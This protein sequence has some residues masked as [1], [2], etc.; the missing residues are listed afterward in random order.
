MFIICPKC[1]A[2]YRIPEGISLDDGQK[3]KC[4]ACGFVFMKGKEAPFL[5]EESLQQTQKAESENSASEAFSTPLFTQP[6]TP[7]EDAPADSLPEAFHPIA[8]KDRKTH[9]WA[10]LFYL[11]VIIGL[12]IAGWTYR[13]LLKPNMGDF[14]TI[15]SNKPSG[16]SRLKQTRK[17]NLSQKQPTLKKET[18]SKQQPSSLNRSGS[19]PVK[20]Q[21]VPKKQKNSDKG[22]EIVADLKSVPPQSNTVVELKDKPISPVS[23]KDA[24][25][26]IPPSLDNA[27]EEVQI[28]LFTGPEKIPE[29]NL[30]IDKI[31]FQVK[32]DESG[33]Q[34]L[35]V[36]GLLQNTG[37]E[38]QSV[39]PL[40]VQVFN[41]D[42]FLLTEKKIHV[43]V[44][45][46]LP[47]QSIPFY[48]G[49]T[50]VPTDV[51]HVDVK[52]R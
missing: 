22:M 17:E 9:P 16:S 4:S 42:N 39:F 3:M 27:D 34:Q 48:T 38:V 45:Q 36:E 18:K 28:P 5:L 25:P 35:L 51:D 8:V 21:S 26:D 29:A 41:K 20:P 31:S 19:V 49:I 23:T 30:I 7:A 11:I 40:I 10:I 44:E 6:I 32:P 14:W 2:K 52:I 43:D 33:N 37:S 13:D 47:G 1:S 50:P 15:S 12:C 46:L 24:A